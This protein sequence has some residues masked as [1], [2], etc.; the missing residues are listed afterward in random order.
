[1]LSDKYQ[2]HAFDSLGKYFPYQSQY[3]LIIYSFEC[4]RIVVNLY[5]NRTCAYKCHGNMHW[6]ISPIGE[7]QSPFSSSLFLSRRKVLSPPSSY[8]LS[9][10]CLCSPP[11]SPIRF[12]SLGLSCD[13]DR[14]RPLSFDL[15]FTLSLDL[16]LWRSLDLC[17]LCSLLYS[18]RFLDR[19]LF[20]PRSLDL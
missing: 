19:R 17:R 3:Y 6:Y 16:D 4:F 10:R 5:L 2:L 20:S 14:S 15:S 18:S 8:S 11:R 12:R 7:T 13:R 9:L 1:M